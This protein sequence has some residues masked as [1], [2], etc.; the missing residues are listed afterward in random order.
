MNEEI[1][2]QKAI[3]R[4]EL[5]HQ[6]RKISMRDRDVASE[7]ILNHVVKSRDYLLAGTIFIYVGQEDEVD[8]SLI[9][10]DALAKG[11]R[12]VVPKI[13]GPGLM[14]AC[15]L[16]VMEDLYPNR[17]GILEPKDCLYRVDPE[18]IDVA[19]IP[20]VA[21]TGDGHRLGHGGGYYDRYLGR[22]HFGRTLIAFQE[23]E[24]EALPVEPF[25]EQVHQII[26]EKG[27]RKIF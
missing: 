10:R 13:I 26:T 21:F 6:R 23:M 16:E 25:D 7:N 27:L 14:E 8:T 3:L 9:I 22:G 17:F 5:I 19:Y 4:R 12:V 18:N 24:V 20:C 15:E 2:E 1:K 11:K